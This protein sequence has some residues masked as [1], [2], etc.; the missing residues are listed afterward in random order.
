[1]VQFL[2]SKSLLTSDESYWL[3]DTSRPWGKRVDF[4]VEILPRKESNWWDKF[5]WCLDE[6][7]TRPGLAVHKQLANQLRDQ[8]NQKM[9][10]YEVNKNAGTIPSS[11]KFSDISEM[12]SKNTFPNILCCR[13]RWFIS[14]FFLKGL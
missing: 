1:M 7:S 2:N 11:G 9:R 6:S 8:L 4:L 12:I 3:M 5:L 10:K 13:P 14:E